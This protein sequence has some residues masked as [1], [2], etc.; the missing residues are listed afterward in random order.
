[1]SNAISNIQVGSLVTYGDDLCTVTASRATHTG[2]CVTVRMP[3]G[4]VRD[5][6]LRNC[7]SASA[8]TPYGFRVPPKRWWF[9]GEIE[10]DDVV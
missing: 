4:L 2:T 1:M 7:R 8:W 6:S 9:Q 5:T 3:D 10:Y